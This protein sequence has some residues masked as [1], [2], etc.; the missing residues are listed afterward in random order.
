NISQINNAVGRRG[1]GVEWRRDGK[2]RCGIKNYF[3]CYGELCQ[4]SLYKDTV[5]DA[6][7]NSQF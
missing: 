5:N 2:E 1:G 7:M 6:V 3:P 4:S